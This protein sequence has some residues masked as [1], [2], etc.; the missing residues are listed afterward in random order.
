IEAVASGTIDVAVAWGPL[1]GYFAA[2][3]NPRLRVAPVQP[4]VDGPFPMTFAISM[5]VRRDDLAFK[6]EIDDILQKRRGDIDAILDSYHVP[7]VRAGQIT[8][9]KR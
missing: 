7:R 5:G 1:G 3:Q 2:L 6:Q 8:E 4:S 9:P